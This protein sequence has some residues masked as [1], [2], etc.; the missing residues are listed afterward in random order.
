MMP[1]T[2][3]PSLWPQ[4][5]FAFAA[6]TGLA[7]F[8]FGGLWFTIQRWA[9]HRHFLSITVASFLVRTAL[10]VAGFYL[11]FQGQ[12]QNGFASLAAFFLT[13]LVLVELV[14]RSGPADGTEPDPLPPAS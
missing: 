10:T 2:M 13:R 3:D 4:I 14:R 6:G 5:A 11:V 7:L 1:A 8:Y 12:W 9:R